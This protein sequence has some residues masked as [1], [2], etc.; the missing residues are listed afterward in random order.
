MLLHGL[1]QRS[2]GAWRRPVDLVCQHDIRE[3]RPPHEPERSRP[4]CR[5]LFQQFR[6]RNVAGH[7]V[8]RELDTTE[9][10]LHRICNRADHQ[11]LC[12]A[13]H[14]D[15][16][17]MAT[18]KDRHEDLVKHC[19][20]AYDPASY[21]FPHPG[22]SVQQLRTFIGTA[23]S[24]CGHAHVTGRLRRCIS[25]KM[26]PSRAPASVS[27][28]S[29]SS[30][31]IPPSFIAKSS[32]YS[33]SGYTT[34]RAAS[35][36]ASTDSSGGTSTRMESHLSTPCTRMVIRAREASPSVS[37]PGRDLNDVT[38]GRLTSRPPR[39]PPASPRQHLPR[40][41]RPLPAQRTEPG[42]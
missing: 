12:E 6:T 20:L 34:S 37:I 18:R 8:W 35:F 25:R 5:I 23:G 13:G 30:T 26:E 10:Q 21:F 39:I 11:S 38:N 19:T 9:V 2:L 33:A 7:Q 1:E 22:C 41:P 15:Q 42:W 16:K 29:S 31:S 17:R 14:A 40:Q 27:E 36:T 3:Y 32:W 4:G 24:W 28:A